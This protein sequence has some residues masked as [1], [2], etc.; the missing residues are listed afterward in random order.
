MCHLSVFPCSSRVGVAVCDVQMHS[1]R[2]HPLRAVVAGTSCLLYVPGRHLA[3]CADRASS[4]DEGCRTCTCTKPTP[5]RPVQTY[6]AAPRSEMGA[7]VSARRAQRFFGHDLEQ[8]WQEHVHQPT[9]D[10]R[11]AVSTPV[12]QVVATPAFSGTGGDDVRRGV[13]SGTDLAALRSQRGVAYRARRCASFG[14]WLWLALERR[15]E[16]H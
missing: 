5:L 1:A 14:G 15:D 4:L 13:P 7:V 6:S 12:R 10:P 9:Q 8:P 3:G 16:L 11:T 2:K